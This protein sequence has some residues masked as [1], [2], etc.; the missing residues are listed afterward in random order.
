MTGETI[1]RAG[2][3]RTPIVVTDRGEPVAVLANLSVL[4]QRRR[5]RILSSDFERLMAGPIVDDSAADLDAV[6]GDR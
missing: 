4:K 5:K 1:R 2:R 6:R 3:A